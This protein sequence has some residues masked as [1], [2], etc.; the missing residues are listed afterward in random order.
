L[1]SSISR[2]PKPDLI[3]FFLGI[4][5]GIVSENSHA[6]LTPSSHQEL[7]WG[8]IWKLETDSLSSTRSEKIDN[9]EQV[10]C[11]TSQVIADMLVSAKDGRTAC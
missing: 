10:S 3:R 7:P 8:R 9:R 11:G 5:A 6:K 2:S 1:R 4:S